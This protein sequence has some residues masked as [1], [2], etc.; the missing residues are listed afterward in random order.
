MFKP[1]FGVKR[2]DTCDM[3]THRFSP[4]GALT[5]SPRTSC[6]FGQVGSGVLV[7]QAPRGCR[8]LSGTKNAFDGEQALKSGWLLEKMF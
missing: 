5:F 2:F 6:A 8:R 1:L 7:V 3:T 4:V